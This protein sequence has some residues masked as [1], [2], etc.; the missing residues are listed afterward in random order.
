MFK[1]SHCLY[2]LTLVNTIVSTLVV[3][4]MTT[5]EV[6]REIV[7]VLTKE[8][9]QELSK[10]LQGTLCVESPDISRNVP[11]CGIFWV[12]VPG[13]FIKCLGVPQTFCV[14]SRI[15][16]GFFQDFWNVWDSSKTNR[17]MSGDSIFPIV[18]DR[19]FL[20]SRETRHFKE[21]LT[22]TFHDLS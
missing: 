15:F 1:H 8:L 20:M 4:R 7:S 21:C 13:H 11:V 10:V 16:S 3:L 19:T 17:E 18:M 5:R 9:S 14:L 22:Q 2:R 6:S 12:F